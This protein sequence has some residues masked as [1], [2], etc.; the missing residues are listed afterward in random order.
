MR[1][2]PHPNQEAFPNPHPNQ[3]AYPNPH[4]NQEAYRKM[5]ARQS[6]EHVRMCRDKYCAPGD[7]T[8]T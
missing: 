6:V 2:S 1:R 5:R 3:E 4:P 7:P 8:Y